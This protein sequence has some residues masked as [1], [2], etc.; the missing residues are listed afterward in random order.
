MD[1]DERRV[2]P[3]FITLRQC[4]FWVDQPGFRSHQVIIV[5]TILDP[6]DASVAELAGLYGMRW[7][8]KLDL[9]SIK[10]LMQMECL[11]CKTPEL[12]RKEIWTHVLAYNLV[13]TIMAQ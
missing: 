1:R 13:P 7:N 10:S 5:T 3:E 9:R 11:R 12:V 2:I 4:R 6:R 8:N